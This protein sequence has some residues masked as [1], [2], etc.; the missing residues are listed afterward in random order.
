MK[1]YSKLRHTVKYMKPNFTYS[2]SKLDK[3]LSMAK[4]YI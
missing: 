2:G 4:W 3:T 1:M